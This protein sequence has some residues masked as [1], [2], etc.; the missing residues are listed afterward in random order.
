M[1]ERVR[2]AVRPVHVTATATVLIGAGL[3]AAHPHGTL[4]VLIIPAEVL[5]V[6]WVASGAVAYLRDIPAATATRRATSLYFTT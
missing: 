1:A 2:A 5:L 6:V 3:A 4:G